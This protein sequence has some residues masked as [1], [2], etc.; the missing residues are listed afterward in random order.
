M[1]TLEK[2]VTFGGC[3]ARFKSDAGCAFVEV[4]VPRLWLHAADLLTLSAKLKD[5]GAA[6]SARLPEQRRERLVNECGFRTV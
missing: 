5:I 6:V 4:D 3:S 1:E 2:E